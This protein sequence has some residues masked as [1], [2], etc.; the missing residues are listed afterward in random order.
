MWSQLQAVMHFSLIG[1][2]GGLSFRLVVLYHVYFT[3]LWWRRAKAGRTNTDDHQRH[4]LAS[5]PKL[6]RPSNSY[7]QVEAITILKECPLRCVLAQRKSRSIIVNLVSFLPITFPW[8]KK[9]FQS[10]ILLLVE[11]DT[12]R[13]HQTQCI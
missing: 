4:V 11:V 7:L 1:G 8:A 9:N 12:F 5:K 6:K 13:V 2:G 10:V 3:A